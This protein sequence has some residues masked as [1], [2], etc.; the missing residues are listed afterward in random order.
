MGTNNQCTKELTRHEASGR[1]KRTYV[2]RTRIVRTMA[3]RRKQNLS[4]VNRASVP[5]ATRVTPTLGVME[6]SF[7]TCCQ[8]R[9]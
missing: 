3:L 4:C 7:A 8:S 1:A 2:K 6:Y 9:R 5:R